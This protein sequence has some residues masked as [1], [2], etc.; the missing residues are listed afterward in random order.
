[1]DIDNHPTSQNSGSEA[2]RTPAN[3]EE[4]IMAMGQQHQRTNDAITLLG[5]MQA[6]FMEKLSNLSGAK[7]VR[8]VD[9]KLDMF[10]G[11]DKT[12]KVLNAEQLLPFHKWFT[13]SRHR[14]TTLGLVES[15]QAACLIGHL[16]GPAQHSWF[17]AYPDSE[18]IT[19]D[20]F[21]TRFCALIPHY[22][23]YCT[24]Q[25]TRKTFALAT[26]VTDVEEFVAFV[27]FSGIMPDLTMHHEVLCDM[28]F[29]KLSENCAH[30]IEVARNAY[31]IDLKASD[32]L[33]TLATNTCSA[34]RRYLQ[35]YPQRGRSNASQPSTD[36][37]AKTANASANGKR[38][39]GNSGPA[40]R[41][42][43][44][45]PAAHSSDAD[46]ETDAALLRK[47]QRCLS[48]GYKPSSP[49]ATHDCDPTKLASRVNGIRHSIKLHKDP[50]SF[51]P[52]S[53][54]AGGRKNHPKK[55]KA[56]R[57]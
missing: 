17:S 36:A 48:C 57:D 30:L 55:G 56:K 15:R 3:L 22:K 31:G 19:P 38:K 16:E 23:L 11:G 9:V 6:Q 21:Y 37:L 34:V 39:R 33:Q 32:S 24:N 4:V 42:A 8:A 46:A 10:S 12:I 54:A 26:L 35:D 13:V 7:P 43:S 50:N 5:A 20:E 25:Y 51:G 1:M 52:K 44:L 45:A 53:G 49:D 14:M 29:S 2:S 41:A 18:A 27:R 47:Y 40:D 28:F